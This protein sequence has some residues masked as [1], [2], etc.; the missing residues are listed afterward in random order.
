MR[1]QHDVLQRE[2]R[3]LHLGLALEDVERGARDD[4]VDAAPSTSARSSTIGPRA[5]FTRTARRA[6][7]LERRLPIRCRVSSLSGTWRLTTSASAS[8]GARG[9]RPRPA[10]ARSRRTPPRAAPS[11]DRSG[12]ADDQ[13]CLPSR[14]DPS[15]NSSE[16]SHSVPRRT[17]RSPSAIR[18][19]SA[20]ISP[21]ASS[22]VVWSGHRACSRRRCRAPPRRARS[23]LLTPTA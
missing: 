5:V 16:N 10:N 14:L 11:R 19:R 23:M 8:S 17:N 15:M 7:R 3:L 9:R 12:R 21:T 22:A 20:S 1:G 2:Q 18:R 13:D 6:H 4:A